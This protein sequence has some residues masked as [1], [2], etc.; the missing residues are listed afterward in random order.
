MSTLNYEDKPTLDYQGPLNPQEVERTRHNSEKT[1]FIVCVIFSALIAFALL[2]TII[3]LPI[4]VAFVFIS[5]YNLNARTRANAVK[6]S[7]KNFPE[8]YKKSVEFASK[9]GIR[10]VPAVYVEQQSGVL[11]AFASAIVGKQYIAI[12][13][14]IVDVAYTEGKDFD[15][16]YFVLAHEFAHHHFKNTSIFR[17]FVRFFS[18]FVPVIGTA[19]SRSMEFSC[20]R[21]AQLLTE[22]DCAREAMLLSAGRHLYGL[23]DLDDYLRNA[24]TEG[25]FF[26]WMANLISTHP[27]PLKRIPA[28]ADPNKESGRLF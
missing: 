21:L 22:K 9:L 7:E 1:L 5:L 10:E 23:V 28:L 25:G 13:A 2:F 3:Y 27:V 18:F 24:R 15:P 12:N 16:V 11:N 19:H 20:D 6:V 17:V 4:I 8:I 26:L 14:E